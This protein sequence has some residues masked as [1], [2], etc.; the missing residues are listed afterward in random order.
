[1][2]I[3]KYFQGHGKE[4]MSDIKDHYGEKK[5]KSIFYATAEKRNQKPEDN[6]TTKRKSIGQMISEG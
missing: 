4:V 3:W 2:P 5:G 6:R 1:M